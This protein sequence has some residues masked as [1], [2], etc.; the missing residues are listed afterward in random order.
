MKDFIPI[1][2]QN[3]T[4]GDCK[5]CQAQCCSALYGSIYSQILKEEFETVY[6]NFPI[7]FIFGSLDFIKPVILLSNGFDFCPH[8]KD[9]RCT[10]YE[11][12]PKVCKTYPLSPNL[13]NQVYIDSSCPEL[14]KGTNKL[15]FEDEVFKN[16]QEKYIQTHFEFENLKRK[17][18]ELVCTIR[19]ENFYKYMGDENSS[20]LNFH[21][22]S[23]ENL[24][25]LELNL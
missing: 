25:K 14:N 15:N 17:D 13:D 1:S 8:L 5:N 7:L 24:E 23:L 4:F 20:Y 11:N 9:F 18:F 3:F 12:R 21:K 16:Y 2:N 6:K 10:I 22:L 19:N